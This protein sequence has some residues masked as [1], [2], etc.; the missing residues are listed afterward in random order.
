[1][2]LLL[3]SAPLLAGVACVVR[4]RLGRPVLFRQQR[5]GRGERLFTLLKFRTMRPGSAPDAE[6]LM[7]LGRFLRRT[8]LDEWPALWNV[9]RGEMS[10]VGPRPLLPRYL[11]HYTRRERKRHR[12]RPGLTGW[13]Q[14]HQ[15][16]RLSWEE[17]LEMDAWYVDNQSLGLDLRILARTLVAAVRRGPV[18]DTP[19]LSFLDQARSEEKHDPEANAPTENPCFG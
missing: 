15:H 14:I 2:I 19:H 10:L 8:S 3:L 12:V 1:M 5:P 11:P 4:L 9:L 16:E 18:V 13:A 17:R 7:P 6:R